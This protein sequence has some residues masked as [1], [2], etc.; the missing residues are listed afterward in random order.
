MY[1]DSSV[2]IATDLINGGPFSLANYTNARYA[3]FSSLLS[4]GFAPDLHLPLVTNWSASVEHAFG[5]REV[6][7]ASYVGAIGRDL[8]RRESTGL[9]SL[10]ADDPNGVA[11]EQ[12]RHCESR[13]V[14]VQLFLGPVLGAFLG[15][16]QEPRLL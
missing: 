8:L 15:P 9:D 2:S 16:D 10:D 12:D 11:L 7:S 3:P 6:V 13:T 5:S 1:Y 4:F 14:T